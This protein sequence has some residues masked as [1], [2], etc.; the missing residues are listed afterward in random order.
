MSEGAARLAA[1]E[2]P[3]AVAQRE[4]STTQAETIRRRGPAARAGPPAGAAASARLAAAGR[5][6]SVWLSFSSLTRRIVSLNLAGLFALV[7]GILYLSQFRAGLIDAR[8]QSLLVQARDHRR[9]HRGVRD[10]RDQHHH[11]RSRT[12]ARSQAGESYGPGRV[13]SGLDFP[14]NPERVAPVLRRLISPTKTRA[15]IYDRDGGLILDSRKLSY[16]VTCCASTCRRRQRGNPASPS[17]R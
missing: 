4:Q 2:N 9:R 13:L 14:I 3:Q 6:F 11:H 15:R 7:T 8:A 1:W 17:G 12:A 16:E 10:R 5:T